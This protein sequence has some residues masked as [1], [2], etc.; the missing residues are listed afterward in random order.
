VPKWRFRRP[1]TSKIF[2]ERGL[3]L[4]HRPISF[5]KLGSSLFARDL[6]LADSGGE[7]ETEDL[8]DHSS[9]PCLSLRLSMKDI[10]VRRDA[11]TENGSISAIERSR[12]DAFPHSEGML[13]NGN[14]MG[15]RRNTLPTLTNI[16]PKS[17]KRTP[18]GRKKRSASASAQSFFSLTQT[19]A[20]VRKW[21]YAVY[22]YVCILAITLIGIRAYVGKVA[23]HEAE[24][25]G[26][27]LG[28]LFGDLPQ[29]RMEVVSANLQR[30]I[31]LSPRN[32]FENE[33]S[34]PLGWVEHLR[35]STFGNANTRL[36]LC[37]YWLGV[38]IVGL[39]IVIRLSAVCEVDTRRK[40]FHFMMVAMLLPATY[41]DPTFAAL[42]LGLMLA[43]FLL[44]DLFRA[45]QLPPLSKS[46]AYFLTP[47]VDGRDLKGPVVISHIF[48]LIGCAIPLWLS[49]GHLPRTG[50]G[51]LSGWEVP[52]R[53]VSMVSGVICVGLG[54]AAASLI[55]RRYGRHKWI[56]GGGKSIE[57]SIAFATAVGLALIL[58][59]AWLRIG[60]W[61]ANNEDPWGLTIGKAGV[62]AGVGSLTEAVLT[63][64]NDNVV[65]PVILWLCVEGLDI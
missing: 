8:V 48:L 59:K 58:A 57:G 37:A 19:Q 7:D 47:Y 41:V 65:V 31:C 51:C 9:M 2:S 25:V 61:P 14:S 46:L 18:S 22:V 5:A 20:K 24:P 6:V 43:I 34:C 21:L 27:A 53:E 10:D 60:Q 11:S 12:A 40:V 15:R 17:S 26:W 38:I 33:E 45:S 55:G 63:G 36:I 54:D 52:R 42:A 4:S 16:G 49:L 62:A 32:G 28:Y 3:K 23:L 50:S 39:A 44:L 13:S 56:W 1:G 64:G 29:F 35:H 30:W